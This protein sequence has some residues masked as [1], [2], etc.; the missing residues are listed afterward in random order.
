MTEKD[1]L[2]PVSVKDTNIV[3]KSNSLIYMSYRLGV[4]EQRLIALL[5]SQIHPADHDFSDYYFSYKD[6]GA[7]CG[8]KRGS[9]L[10]RD[11]K[12][13]V[14]ELQS[15]RLRLPAVDSQGN[16][17]EI[18][19]G[20]VSSAFAHDSITGGV[21][22]RFEPAL[23]PYLLALRERFTSYGLHQIVQ[24]RSAYSIR[25]YEIFKSK[26]R[27]GKYWMSIKEARSIAGLRDTEYTTTAELTR[28]VLSVA[29]KEINSKTDLKIKLARRLENRCVVGWTA[30]IRGQKARGFDK[31]A[32]PPVAVQVPPPL[33]LDE[34]D[35]YQ[36]LYMK[37]LSEAQLT[38]QENGEF[39]EL[40]A[41]KQRHESF[42]DDAPNQPNLF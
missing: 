18:L 38:D 28:R 35:R 2:E 9:N 15:R 27:L 36:E 1:A 11:T 13:A 8:L 19:T 29:V 30:H 10:V 40:E 4:V 25:F 14:M 20:W 7:L 3:A 39:S 34:Q 37:F 41:K 22:L 5:A 26:Q 31:S 32:P 16:K 23:K 12:N 21:A 24:L 42:A 6:L 33:S 17:G